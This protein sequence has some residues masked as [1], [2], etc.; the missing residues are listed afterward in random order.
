MYEYDFHGTL[1]IAK[2]RVHYIYGTNLYLILT[3]LDDDLDKMNKEQKE[4]QNNMEYCK[5]SDF[6]FSN[7][8]YL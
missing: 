6:C 4:L 7:I 1:H 3:D 2:S 8:F 5:V